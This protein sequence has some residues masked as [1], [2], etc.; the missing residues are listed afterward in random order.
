MVLKDKDK[1][2]TDKNKNKRFNKKLTDKDLK[3]NNFN[4]HKCQ[5]DKDYKTGF[6][7]PKFDY[8]KKIL[9]DLEKLKKRKN[10]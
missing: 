6:F 2:L 10:I 9:D 8:L 3:H 4:F 7:S 1:N 5:S